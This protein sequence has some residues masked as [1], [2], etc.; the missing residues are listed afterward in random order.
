MNRAIQLARLF[1]PLLICILCSV[2]LGAF[3]VQYGF[4]EEPCPLCL[5]QRAGMVGVATATLFQMRFG[6]SPRHYGLILLF[7][8]FGGAVALRHIALGAC[9]NPLDPEDS[10]P[11][12]T[13]WGF[14][15][16][17]WSFL[18]F[19]STLLYSALLLF[20][21]PS[22]EAELG[23]R[24]LT[25]WEKGAAYYLVFIVVANIASTFHLCGWGLC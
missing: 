3:I 16:Y 7:V 24:R 17:T 22:Q 19:S 12:F 4:H 15:L 25:W 6:L 2:L 5:L 9:P 1:Q 11:E 20:F 21:L 13:V 8:L 18:V 10:I 23:V 14:T